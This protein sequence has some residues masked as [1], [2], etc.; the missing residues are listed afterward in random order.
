MAEPS[1][2]S[3]VESVG[4]SAKANETLSQFV[5]RVLDQ[6]SLSAWLPSA[7]L[8]L[9]LTFV[10]QLGAA[11]DSTDMKSIGPGEALSAAVGALSRTSLGGALLLV[12]AVVVL[13]ML[14]QAFA[15]E[16]IRTLEGYWGTFRFV[17]WIA[18]RRCSH[19][20]RQLQDLED[21]YDE[22]TGSAW[23]AARA[24]IEREQAEAI[25]RRD[26]EADI[27][28]WTEG[29]LAYLGAK[30]NKRTSPVQLTQDDR[31]RAL[32]I[33]WERYAPPDLLRR[34]V[35]LDKR[36]RD[37]PSRRRTLPTRLGNV[38]RT[39]EDQ[40]GRERVETLVLEVYDLLPPSLRAQHNDQR[41][42]L[43]LYCSMIFV[44]A[45]ITA[46]A[47]ARLGPGHPRY[48]ISAIVAGGLGIW[49]TYR[50]AIASARMYGLLL[51]DIARRY[52]P[53]LGEGDLSA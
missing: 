24:A 41:N 40:T 31:M 13:T 10:F 27:R 33:P 20:G 39:H 38:L 30:L 42:R 7:A 44:V 49:V 4:R 16:A 37:F 1:E 17:E 23:T 12:A 50:A 36:L 28:E 45:L 53:T 6:L 18:K 48:A 3:A 35:N 9:S 22:L 15:F 14:T 52:P 46:I 26:E 47:T 29:M 8:V 21:R 19:F 43:D 2:A 11:L 32:K 25:D 51:V 34:Q 5:A